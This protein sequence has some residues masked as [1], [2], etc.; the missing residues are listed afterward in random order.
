[1]IDG[2]AL[3]MG[4]DGAASRHVTSGALRYL[5]FRRRSAFYVLTLPRHRNTL[6]VA[7]ARPSA[8]GTGV[9]PSVLR[10][11][12]LMMRHEAGVLLREQSDAFDGLGVSLA[13]EPADFAL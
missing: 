5:R 3:V 11:V 8:T 10:H 13:T 2:L 6:Q 4:A 7:R 9:F 12:L 1:M